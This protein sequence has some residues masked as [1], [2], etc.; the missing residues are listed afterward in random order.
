MVNVSILSVHLRFVSGGD[1]Q[2]S[3]QKSHSLLEQYFQKYEGAAL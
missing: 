1:R 2:K 3:R